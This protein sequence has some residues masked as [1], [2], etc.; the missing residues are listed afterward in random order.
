MTA[1]NVLILGA[2]SAI[3][4]ATARRLVSPETRFILVARDAEELARHAADLRLRGARVIE[5]VTDL[6]TAEVDAVLAAAKDDGPIDLALLSYGSLTD[7]N[8]A[9][10]DLDYA[11]GEFQTNFLSAARWILAIGAQ[12]ALQ[13]SGVLV[14]IG[15][16]AGDRG[17]Q[18]NFVYGSAK[19]GL[20]V[21]V[22]GMAH[23]LS[24]R[25]GA[26]AIL[27][28]PGFVDTPMTDH[29][30]KAGP[31]WASPATIA[32]VI[33]TAAAGSSPIVYAPRLWGWIMLVIRTLPAPLFHR[34]RL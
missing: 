30:A 17:R 13:S 22:Q 14:V 26:R 25:G 19:A 33:V 4:V 27:I 20:A 5:H 6:A 31:L 1:R 23:D 7:Q 3:A 12:L 11:A 29:L 28:K 8:R 32:K 34:T 10:S 24:R 16:V 15:S 2:L 21:L 9:R 18:S